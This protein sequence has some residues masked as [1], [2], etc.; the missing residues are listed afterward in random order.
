[1]FYDFDAVHDRRGTYCTQWDYIQDR[2]GEAGILPFSISDH[3]F[4]V[5]EPIV[6]RLHKVVDHGIYG[7]TRWNHVDFKG[8][9]TGFIARRHGVELPD[10]WVVYSPSVMYTLARLMCFFTEVGD[11]VAAFDPMYDSFIKII[12]GNGRR[13]EP[14][15][16]V[17]VEGHYE[18][19][20]EALESALSM[21]RVLLLCS[22]HNPTGRVW[23]AD[24]L[25]RIV[26]L[27]RDHHVKI[28]SDEIHMDLTFG[29]SVHIPALAL[30]SEYPEIYLASS[31]SKTFN[32]AGL[33]GSNALIPNDAD[34]DQF[35]FQTRNR[36]LL[37]SA[38][39]MGMHA[40]MVGYTECDDYI[41]QLCDYLRGNHELVRSF[42]EKQ[43]P[44][45]SFEVPES[46]CLS[47][48]DARR[49]PFTSAQIQ[50]ALVHVGRV[51]IMPGETYGQSGV[52]YL[53]MCIGGPRSKV[54]EG[55]RRFK[56]GMEALRSEGVACEGSAK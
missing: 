29:D 28:I 27:C 48:I 8:A 50:D 37:N 2:F 4:R 1:M 21:S 54:E 53:R 31:C 43:M 15:P 20:F 19:D 14:V 12:E 32:T 49:V 45:F 24:E 6:E 40:H 11:G 10:G 55:L 51:G 35:L 42:I 25:G 46:T 56:L 22:P 17:N 34:R 41:D 47:W 38:N 3:D 33:G 13:L 52:G 23:A 9:V 5:P 18:I 7:Y 30:W 44:E 36:D 39:V 26:A 16:L